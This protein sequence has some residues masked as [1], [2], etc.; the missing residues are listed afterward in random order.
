M[1]RAKPTGGRAVI[2]AHAPGEVVEDDP[3]RRLHRKLNYFPTPPWAARAGAEIIKDLA[4][5]LKTV[6]EPACGEGHMAHGLRDYFDVVA[7]DIH[8]FG[9]G[10]VHDF[11]SDDPLPFGRPDFIITNPPFGQAAEF[12]R[13]GLEVALGGVSVLCRT[14]FIE[15]PGRFKMFWGEHPLTVMAPFVERVSLQLGSWDPGLGAMTSYSWFNWFKGAQPLPLIP[16][17]PGTKARLH[18]QSDVVKFAQAA[19]PLF[20]GER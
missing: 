12:V 2:E 11:L 5:S 4:P 13:R 18:K 8:P 20:E 17:P 7:S 14:S 10:A 9:Y 3:V 15:T 1:A 6:W 19:G 16:I